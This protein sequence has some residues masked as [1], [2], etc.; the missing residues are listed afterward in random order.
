MV[1]ERNS[2][3]FNNTFLIIT[4]DFSEK[5][6]RGIQGWL[7]C[8]LLLGSWGK[9]SDGFLGSWG[10][11]GAFAKQIFTTGLTGWMHKVF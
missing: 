8:Q 1:I 10:P 5:E 6:E 11:S 7:H 3:L 2:A 4:N 9:W